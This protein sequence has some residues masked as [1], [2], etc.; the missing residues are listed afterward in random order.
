MADIY[1]CKKGEKSESLLLGR[2]RLL[3]LFCKL[4]LV[5]VAEVCA[6]ARPQERIRVSSDQSVVEEYPDLRKQRWL[7][8]HSCLRGG[9]E[10]FLVSPLER[11]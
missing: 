6:R 8:T 9:K 5:L 3:G 7:V 1:Y 4:V 11:A 2:D 10:S